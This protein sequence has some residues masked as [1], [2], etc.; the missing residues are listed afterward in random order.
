MRYSHRAVGCINRLPAR[1]ACP[2]ISIRR[3]LSSICTSTSSAS[4]STATVA[5]DVCIRPPDSV[6]GTRCVPCELPIQ[7]LDELNTDLTVID[8]IASL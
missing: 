6:V 8:A 3:S 4:G 2:E 7:I 1:P 5:A